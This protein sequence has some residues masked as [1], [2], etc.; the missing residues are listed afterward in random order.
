MTD[1]GNIGPSECFASEPTIRLYTTHYSPL[2]I[3]FLLNLQERVIA[4]LQNFAW[5][6]NS[7]K[8]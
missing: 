4:G 5:A 7:Q 6:P 2:F 3:S 8:Y 1:L